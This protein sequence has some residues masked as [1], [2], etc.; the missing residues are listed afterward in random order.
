MGMTPEGKIKKKL[1][2]MLK[3]K[4]RHLFYFPPQAG[5]FGSAGIPDRIV[6]YKGLFIGI[7]CKADAK[8]KKLTPLQNLALAKIEEAGGIGF[9]VYDDATIQEVSKYLDLHSTSKVRMRMDIPYP[10]RF[11]EQISA[12]G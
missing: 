6:C 4:G 3:S 8:K 10:A 9:V 5:A 12:G 2:E 11:G 1:D 7:E